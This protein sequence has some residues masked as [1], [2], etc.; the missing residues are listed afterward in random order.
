MGERTRTLMAVAL[1]LAML[2]QPAWAVLTVEA[3]D[4][5]GIT[6]D[7]EFRDDHVFDVPPGATVELIKKPG[8]QKPAGD[9]HR[10]EGR[11]KG[12]K[13]TLDDYIR[14]ECW[15]TDSDCGPMNE[16]GGGTKSLDP[17]LGGVRS[18]APKK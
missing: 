17:G 10:I 1:G 16:T 7:S 9:T 13:G 4:A 14:R 8:V 12:Y 18:A 15:R 5:P 3:S 6:I 11:A 2:S